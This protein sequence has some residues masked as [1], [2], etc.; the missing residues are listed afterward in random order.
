MKAAAGRSGKGAGLIT[1]PFSFG[2]I[3][4]GRRCQ[5]LGGLAR[6]Y[7]QSSFA[8]ATKWPARLWKRRC[9]QGGE[10]VRTHLRQIAKGPK[11]EALTGNPGE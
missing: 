6:P 1:G 7:L 4:R 10:H 11:I 8:F 9:R 2:T 5:S 3:G